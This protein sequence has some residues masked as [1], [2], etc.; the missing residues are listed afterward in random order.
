MSFGAKMATAH[1]RDAK[2]RRAQGC[3]DTA[4]MHE[5]QAYRYL[6][7]GSHVELRGV[8]LSEDEQF[9]TSRF[10]CVAW[11]KF[12]DAGRRPEWPRP[13]G[14]RREGSSSCESGSIASG[15]ERAYCTCD[16]CW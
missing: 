15:G 8:V 12:N 4:V 9:L 14:P 7:T 5:E 3:F 13:F 16:R 2:I 1:S 11:D 10:D 6:T